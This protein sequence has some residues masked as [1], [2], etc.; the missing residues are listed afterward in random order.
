[1]PDNILLPLLFTLLIPLAIVGVSLINAGLNRTRSAAHSVLSSMC[2]ASVAVLV[3]VV[4][5]SAIAGVSGQPAHVVHLA[6]HTWGWAGAGQLFARSIHPADPHNALVLIFELFAVGLAAQ[7]PVSSGGERWRLT[8]VCCSTA[9]LAGLIF[10]YIEY[11]TWGGGFLSQL[12]SNLGIGMGLIDAG[13]AGVIQVLGGLVALVV[14]WL[15]GPR[16]GKFTADGIPTAMP[17][18]NAVI[19]VM[20]SLLALL[21]WIGLTA[22]GAILFYGAGPG[23]ALFVVINMMLAASGGAVAAFVT[24]RVRFGKPDTSLTAN[25]WVAGLVAASAGAPFLKVP[26]A[27]LVGLLAGVVVVFAIEVVEIRMRVDDPAGAIS[28]HAVG[29]IW[30]LLAAGMFAGD[31]EGQF[32]AQLVAIGTLVGFALP[33]AFGINSLINR[34]IPYRLELAGER[35]GI[36]LFELGAGAYPEFVIQR[37]DFLRR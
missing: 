2:A 32:L 26:Q 13:G 20:G 11:W 4:L 25:G 8:A 19:V 35:Q 5:G 7:I 14:A 23:A 16:Q 9:L 22:A 18:H 34:F 27:M 6:G 33:L 24:T 37:D 28:V 1:M 29:G 3:F 30:G 10:P 21:G 12:G 31:K 15:L 36:D 17:G